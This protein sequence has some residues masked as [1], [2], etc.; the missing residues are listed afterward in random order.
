MSDGCIKKSV[1]KIIRMLLMTMVVGTVLTGITWFITGKIA[2]TYLIPFSIFISISI[3]LYLIEKRELKD[4]GMNFRHKDMLFLAAGIVTS[5]VFFIIAISVSSLLV[6]TNRFLEYKD[7]IF[8][9]AG[10]GLLGVLVIPLSEEMIYRGYI[11][12][13]T[14]EKYKFYQISIIAALLFSMGHWPYVPGTPLV[15]YLL[16][17]VIATFLFGLLFNNIA[18]ITKTIWFGVGLH[19]SY[20]YIGLR[21]FEGNHPDLYFIVIT[22]AFI[23]LG[24]IIT[25]SIRKNFPND[26]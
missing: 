15:Q 6:G 18:E 21:I 3:S 14:F 2:I 16:T 9:G 4:I 17:S 11:L 23:I 1:W 10:R 8:N 13:D 22:I 26:E 5:C 24:L 7:M 12:K 19:W 25:N 20:N